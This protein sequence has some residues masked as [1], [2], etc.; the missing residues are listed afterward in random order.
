VLEYRW[1]IHLIFK[2]VLY[3]IAAILLLT[4][5][6]AAQISG[7]CNTGQT[8]ATPAGCT[9][10]LVTPNPQGGGPQRD[11]NWA[12]AY[13]YP[14]TI[15][16]E[17]GPCDLKSFVEPWVDTPFPTWLANSASSASEWI[18]P[19]NGE[20][21]VSGGSYVYAT[22]FPVPS[23]L[24]GGIVPTSVTINGRLSSDNA[25]PGFYLE[26]PANSSR[27]SMVRGL[28]VPINSGTDWNQW[29][30]FSFTR[31]VT[32]GADAY[33]FVLVLNETLL[34]SLPSPQGLRVEF[35]ATSAFN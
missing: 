33:L 28:P 4:T 23:A 12:L 29:T 26:S 8:R 2:S 13:P 31:P 20:N 1:R 7:L 11:N 25:T 19:F 30:D 10:V 21:N 24:A 18:T 22:K 9:G 27:C 34:S 5:V 16:P 14:S 6:A 32:A 15:S 17:N 3:V 35:F